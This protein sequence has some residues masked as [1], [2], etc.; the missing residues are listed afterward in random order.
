MKEPLRTPILYLIT[1]G[2]STPENFN[3]TKPKLI[4]QISD[5]VDAGVSMIQIREKNLT[6]SQVFEIAAT[7]V[8]IA[9]NSAT[10]IL[11]NDRF[12][13]A[14]AA[15]ADGVHLTA[16][17]MR[18]D[19]VRPFVPSGF[20]IGVSTHTEIEAA[21]AKTNG[22]DFAVLG[23]VFSTPGKDDPIGEEKFLSIAKELNPFP[24]L[25]LGGI[26]KNNWRQLIENGATGF[27]AIR[28]FEDDAA[29]RMICNETRTKNLF[30]DRRT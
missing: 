14:V 19:V 15:G 4:A 30:D 10:A 25:A 5:A 6:A 18:P 3:S 17:S 28:L 26:D 9:G 16:T 8:D 12:D 7:A 22:A 21:N 24:V 23:P 1:P 2:R 11:V 13:I 27:A 20:L 29:I